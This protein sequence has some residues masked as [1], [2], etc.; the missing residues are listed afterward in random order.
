MLL[1]NIITSTLTNVVQTVRGAVIRVALYGYL[2]FQ[3]SQL[4]VINHS[5]TEVH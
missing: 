4:E 5:N 3:L 2:Y 1:F